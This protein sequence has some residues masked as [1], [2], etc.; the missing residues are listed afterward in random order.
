M[1]D[2]SLIIT[3]GDVSGKGIAAAVL[4]S[5]QA[6]IR[7][8]AVNAPTSMAKLMGEFNRAIFFPLRTSTPRCSSRG[9]MAHAAAS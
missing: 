1:T 6:S 7:S 9:S 5:I 4:A 2:S 3:L 8:Q